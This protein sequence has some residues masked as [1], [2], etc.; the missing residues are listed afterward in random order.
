[1]DPELQSI[2]YT[3]EK[4]SQAIHQID[5]RKYTLLDVRY[6]AKGDQQSSRWWD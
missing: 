5:A 1:M 6:F 2:Q 3:L 4:Q